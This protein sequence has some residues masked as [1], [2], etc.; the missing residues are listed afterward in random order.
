M[1]ILLS[2]LLVKPWLR[3]VALA[4]ALMPGIMGILLFLPQVASGPFASSHPAQPGPAGVSH[5]GAEANTAPASTSL[6]S[7][8][9]SYSPDSG[10]IPALNSVAPASSTPGAT[11]AD[12]TVGQSL[13]LAASNVEDFS[14]SAGKQFTSTWTNLPQ[15]YGDVQPSSALLL[16][17][18]NGTI[19]QNPQDIA[20]PLAFTTPDDGATPSQ[21]AALDRLRSEFAGSLDAQGTDP[22]SS[23]YA[24][25]WRQEQEAN[26]SSFEQQFGTQAFIE[27]QLAQAHGGAN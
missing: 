26:D 3:F 20:V 19:S 1:S 21:Q 11:F 12:S 4:N 6:S 18:K 25:L 9:F 16:E 13:P 2:Q 5:L 15:N 10:I 7:S 8:Q 17:G 22:N 14:H 24:R 27:A 23:E